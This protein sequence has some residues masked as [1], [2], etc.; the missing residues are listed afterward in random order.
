MVNQ[1]QTT[2]IDRIEHKIDAISEALIKLQVEVHGIREDAKELVAVEKEHEQTLKRQEATLAEHQRRSLALEEM[3][4]LTRS[5]HSECPARASMVWRQSSFEKFKNLFYIIT[6]I[7][8][9]LKMFGIGLPIK[10]DHIT[11]AASPSSQGK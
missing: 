6:A 2:R 1:S 10:T 7:V 4:E 3:V 8:V 5:Q 9:L 11:D